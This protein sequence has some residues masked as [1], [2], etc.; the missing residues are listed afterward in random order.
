MNRPISSRAKRHA[1]IVTVLLAL[2]AGG[3][4]V[5]QKKNAATTPDKADTAAIALELAAS[6]LAHVTDSTLIQPLSLSG[7][8]NPIRQ[9]VIGAEVDGVLKE[10]L[11]R[12]GDKVNT[13]QVIARFEAGD[14]NN[15][16]RN[17][18]ANRERYKAELHLAEKTRER[19]A[20]LLK[21]GFISPTVYDKSENAV[22][23]AAAQL[24]AEEAQAAVAN[25]AVSDGVVRAPFNGIIASR[26]AEPGSRVNVNQALFNL[27]DLNELE[28]EA[29]VPVARLPAVKL[30]QL[31]TLKI[32]GFDQQQ[33]TGSI[34]RIAPVADAGSRMVP[35][36]VKVNN[37]AHSLRGGMFAQGEATL[38][39]VEHAATLPYSAI[40]DLDGK[41]PYVL[42]V[43]N[44]KIVSRP[45]K[46]GLMNELTKQVAI[47]EGIKSGAV[48]VIAKI[49]NLKPG[50]AVKL[51][52][53]KPTA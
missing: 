43:E 21:Q 44:G 10:V 11:V 37:P 38:A 8:L 46:L 53:A 33:F 27:V 45:I 39:K 2:A 42:A 5:A 34:E 48:V 35:V 1:V 24:R 13:G 17:R 12:P 52:V 51:P 6:D 50:Q 49:E 14:R 20:D 29:N 30:G 32:E 47:T 40:R 9:T 26:K 19:D 36:Y 22:A 28:Y 25:K 18:I 4:V 16:L 7:T 31:V 3:I 23:V 41:A 15:Q